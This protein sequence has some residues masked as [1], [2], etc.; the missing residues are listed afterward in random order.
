[1]RK[2]RHTLIALTCAALVPLS[3]TAQDTEAERDRGA[4]QAFLEDKLSTAGRDIR[5]EGFE[6]ALSSNATLD[7]LTIADADGVW[8]TLSDVSL[9][10]SRT[11]LLR[12]RLEIE[13]LSAGEIAIPRRPLPAPA[14]ELADTQA[15]PFALPEL[16]VAVNIGT[17]SVDRLDLGEGVIG[18]AAVF[19]MDGS[20][21]LEDG[22]G[23]ADIDISR[24][25]G[26]KGDLTLSAAYA[27]A[28]RDLRIDLNLD[29]GSGGLV[30]TLVNL[31]G[32]P[33]VNLRVTADAPLSDFTAQI[34]LATDDTPR[35]TGQARL[36]DDIDTSVEVTDPDVPAPTLQRVEAF[37][38][39]DI[40]ALF[41]PEL[42]AFFG[43]QSGLGVQAILY[44]D[45][46]KDITDLD[47]Q[48]EQMSVTGSL[49]IGA[50]GLPSA[51]D[52][53]ADINAGEPVR[54]PVSGDETY[55][56]RAL[57]LA[58]FDA[59]LGNEWTLDGFVSGL[60]RAGLTVGDAQITGQGH[61]NAE[62]APLFDG[63]FDLT[64]Q[65]IAHRDAAL[66]TAIGPTARAA[67]SVTY[68]RDAP[69]R[70]ND[71]R[72]T[73]GD[74]TLGGDITIGRGDEGVPITADLRLTSTDISR[75]AD[76]AARPLG[77]AADLIVSGTYSPLSGAF[78]ISSQARLTDPITGVAQ[79]DALLAGQTNLILSAARDTN[80]TILRRLSVR[81]DLVTLEARGDID[82]TDASLDFDAALRDLTP[83]DLGLSRGATATGNATWQQGSAITLTALDIAAAGTNMTFSGTFD[84]ND[85]ALPVKGQ[86][87][88]TSGD[89][90]V[91]SKLAGRR[92][93]GSVDLNAN[94]AAAL[95][96]QTYDLDLS[97]SGTNLTI[98]VAQ[99]DALL[100]GQSQLRFGGSYGADGID[101]R[102][103]NASSPQFT[104]SITPTG[105]AGDLAIDATLNNLGIIVP[106]FP[107]TARVDGTIRPVGPD[108]TVDVEAT[109]PGGI[110]AQIAG[111]VAGMAQTIDLRVS[112]NAPL[113]LANGFIAPRAVSGLARFEASING[114][115]GL[116]AVSGRLS[117]SGARLVA[118]ALGV[119]VDGIGATVSLSGGRAV[120]DVTGAFA[121]GGTVAING[122]VGLGAGNPADMSITLSRAVLSDPDLYQT[123]LNAALALTGPLTGGGRITGTVDLL[124]TEL[125]IPSGGGIV[126]GIPDNLRHVGES[127]ASRR[128]R[129]WAGLIDTGGASS[130]AGSAL[131]LDVIVSAPNQIFIR[132]R[133]LDAEL[134]G[135]IRVTGT[136]ADVIPIG[137]FEL[138]RGRLEI[139]GQRL[140]LDEGLIRLQGSLDPYLRLVAT[141]SAADDTVISVV[142][143][144]PVS[145]PEVVFESQ[146]E[147]PQDEVLARLLFERGTQSLSPLQAVQLANA[148]A[149]LSGRS[150][151]GVISALRQNFGLD[152]LDI[153]TDE[154]GG[155]AVRAGKYISE[156]VYTDV[157]VDSQGQTEINLNLDVTPSFTVRGSVGDDGNTGV[158]VFFEKNY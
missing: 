149:V 10:W 41:T 88:A 81:G 46:R 117:T 103:L 21:T 37:L 131:G 132:G 16:P 73:S 79:A 124:E 55:I 143:E 74:T 8:I 9:V 70:L 65:D 63:E 66:A 13:T 75:F 7:S 101:I 90:S 62:G 22:Q 118:P 24:I 95:R 150:D 40:R 85:P 76:L 39:G 56:E 127:A 98:G 99:A 49:S 60:S 126:G 144:G 135:R 31:P 33:S 152:D 5:I 114:A 51:F 35:L 44:P 129:D 48:T 130:G 18:P 12:G 78:D 116:D 2:F 4:L 107:G 34:A 140:D 115:P 20:L 38:D 45:G 3:A 14:V 89:L 32:A 43:A 136:T 145:E 82:V 157:T 42:H 119:A 25:D 11:A 67:L 36:R 17:L 57:I 86:V 108:W 158:G 96:D 113:A 47:L 139:L 121:E 153:S 77:G 105:D 151:G 87:D 29:E 110:T 59:D 54:L 80:G 120:V 156:N 142:I 84:P 93:G 111:T 146:P 6:G 19:N 102:L 148:V 15:T 154:S 58:Q 104:A 100:R 112:G 50:A 147:L 141:T 1:M 61:I 128:T 92:L 137:R 69:V 83:L 26:T 122:S 28:T 23:T 133:G 68:D 30:S 64:G 94:G 72:I 106:D 91:F 125:R 97:L 155:A 138:V 109:G 71:V 123:R 53:R 134:G 27:N 52:L